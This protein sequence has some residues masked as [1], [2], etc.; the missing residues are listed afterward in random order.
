M[1]KVRNLLFAC[2]LVLNSCSKES[3]TST[4]SLVEAF[5]FTLNIE[6]NPQNG[7][8]LGVI[9]GNNLENAVFNIAKQNPSNAFSIDGQTGALT[10]QDAAVFDYEIN[11]ILTATLTVNNQVS[12]DEFNVEVTLTDIDD[13][14]F[15]LTD[16]KD[17]YRNAERGSWV[18]ITEKEYE[19]LANSLNKTTRIGTS[20]EEYDANGEVSNSTGHFTFALDGAKIPE[21]GFVFAFK[22]DNA[23]S[24]SIRSK[25]KFTQ[26]IWSGYEDFAAVLPY[27]EVGENFF[28]LKGNEMSFESEGFLGFYNEHGLRW[29]RTENL[30]TRF[31]FGFGDTN[32]MEQNYNNFI[33]RYQGLSTTIK[34][35]D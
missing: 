3:D 17:A 1:K 4:Q 19:I 14:E 10:V 34:Q 31:F 8:S 12:S 20:K 28:L 24:R 13:I 7:A 33:P 32:T 2:L 25:L 5:D 23:N 11:P 9:E 21:G 30:D 29:I 15:F 22:Y 6:E 35:W 16:S 18:L 27:H 26:D